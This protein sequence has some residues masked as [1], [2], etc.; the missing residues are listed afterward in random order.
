MLKTIETAVSALKVT[1]TD[2]YYRRQCWEVLKGFLIASISV[3]EN[4]VYRFLCHPR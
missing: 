4:N 2:A 3:E 1:T